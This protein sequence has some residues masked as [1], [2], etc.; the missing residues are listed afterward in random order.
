MVPPADRI[1]V[2]A[3]NALPDGGIRRVWLAA[4]DIESGNAPTARD[5]A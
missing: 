5:C 2:V 4:Y 1:I 3:S